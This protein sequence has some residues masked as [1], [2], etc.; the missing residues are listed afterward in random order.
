MATPSANSPA[1]IRA[2]AKGLVASVPDAAAALTAEQDLLALA[3]TTAGL[4][5]KQLANPALDLPLRLSLGAAVAEKLGTRPEVAKLYEILIENDLLKALP[6]LSRAVARQRELRFGIQVVQ[7]RSARPLNDAQRAALAAAF[8]KKT[9]RPVELRESVDPAL[10][11]GAVAALGSEIFDA[12]L[13][14]LIGAL[15]KAAAG[16]QQ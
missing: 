8:M 3:Q 15:E 9:G 4:L 13:P 6:L 16:A 11:A 1:G 12:S 2:L 10:L 7:V 5:H 14:G